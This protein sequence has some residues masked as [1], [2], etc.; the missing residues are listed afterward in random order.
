MVTYYVEEN[1]QYVDGV[2]DDYAT[3]Q[4]LVNKARGDETTQIVFDG[5]T[6]YELSDVVMI[7]KDNVELVGNN[8]KTTFKDN[9]IDK[10]FSEQKG[11][12]P[13]NSSLFYI[14]GDK[15]T[16]KDFNFDANANHNYFE[17]DGQKV[18]G[19]MK[20]LNTVF[21]IGFTKKDLYYTTYGVYCTADDFVIQDCTFEEVGAPINFGQFPTSTH[22][23]NALIEGCNISNAF[24]DAVVLSNCEDVTVRDCN[25]ENCQRK[26]I[27]LYR[28]VTNASIYD[29]VIYQSDNESDFRKW[30]P[31]WNFKVADCERA[32]IAVCNPNYPEYCSDIE[33]HNNNIAVDGRCLYLRNFS[34]D[35]S[36]EDNIFLSRNSHAID[37]VNGLQGNVKIEGNEIT[38]NKM[39]TT[40]GD[41]GSNAIYVKFENYIPN[42]VGGE[43][44]LEDKQLELNILNNTILNAWV[45]I[46]IYSDRGEVINGHEKLGHMDSVKI[47]ILNN[48][49][50][51]QDQKILVG[52]NL[53]GEYYIDCTTDMTY[54][55]KNPEKH[56]YINIEEV[57]TKY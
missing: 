54:Y 42:A 36:V 3:L 52:N 16:I 14:T 33:V 23:E 56:K 26:G 11:C 55:P 6:T 34:K 4:A 24:R 8:C 17:V 43:V 1:I 47:N 39:Q 18:Y 45:G 2:R 22:C 19:W 46:K 7:N 40:N 15:C 44:S 29:N 57:S 48:E 13:T 12:L 27:Q 41:I 37:I 5:D 31:T 53:N 50:T 9:R 51:V 21:P 35:I 32:G 38:C 28:N 49:C 10:Y 25:F 30:Y 20:D